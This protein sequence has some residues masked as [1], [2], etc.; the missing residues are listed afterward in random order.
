[1]AWQSSRGRFKSLGSDE[2]SR[3]SPWFQIGSTL[4]M[5]AIWGVN[6]WMEHHSVF[7]SPYKITY[8]IKILKIKK[9][10]WSKKCKANYLQQIFSVTFFFNMW[11]SLVY[12][13]FPLQALYYWH[14]DYKLFSKLKV[15]KIFP[16]VIS[17]VFYNPMFHILGVYLSILKFIF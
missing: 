4:A 12:W 5:A 2:T 3:R 1:M 15:L 8:K 16:A 9:N 13:F 10:R 14:N 7:P 6:K 11:W 17:L